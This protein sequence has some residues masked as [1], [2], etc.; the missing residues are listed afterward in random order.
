MKLFSSP[1]FPPLEKVLFLYVM[2]LSNRTIRPIPGKHLSK[3]CPRTRDH[4][5]SHP[6]QVCSFSQQFGKARH[7]TIPIHPMQACP[8]CHKRI[9]GL[10][11]H[12]FDTTGVPA[13]K[14][15]G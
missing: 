2:W 8:C 3:Q 12:F 11:L 7:N 15:A 10:E 5:R 9:G 13:L 1:V 4:R 14:D 6:S